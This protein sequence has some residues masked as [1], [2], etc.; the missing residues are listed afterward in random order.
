MIW[1][2]IVFVLAAVVGAILALARLLG[3]RE[4]VNWRDA[5]R[6]GQLA[7][8][9]GIGVHYVERG[10]GTPVVL[11]HGFGAHTYSYRYLIPELAKDHRVVALDL[12]GFGYSERVAR[13]D[14]TMAAQAR[15]VVGLMDALGMET[16]SLVGHSMGGAVAMRVAST[17]PQRVDRLV[18]VASAS[19]DRVPMPPARLIRP[20]L[21]LFAHL[22]SG[23]LMRRS[24]Y[25]PSI[26]TDEM[27]QAYRRPMTI[28]GSMNG[29]NQMLRD[30][31]RDTPIDY[32]GITQPTLL[33][34]GSH[35]RVLPS[36]MLPRLRARLPH[37]E[38]VTVDQAGHLLLEE[39][40]EECNA[41]IRRFLA[42]GLE[43]AAREGKAA[44]AGAVRSG[45]DS[46]QSTS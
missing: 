17:C 21:P 43:A 40:P 14:Y 4:K 6:P 42:G 24:V 15:V 8:V 41:A 35:E 45:V 10:S 18:L 29:L 7:E 28:K 22:L 33:L 1:R 46:G 39:R 16:A 13:S 20:F 2:K 25:D 37:A 26:V 3:R 32:A 5:E 36:W 11:I 30:A 38:L 19:G 44:P 9:D 23:W 27:R 34:W 12:K 31:R